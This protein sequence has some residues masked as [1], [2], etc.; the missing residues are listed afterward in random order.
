MAG[1][2][3]FLD[4]QGGV[5]VSDGSGAIDSFLG[6]QKK[7]S[8]IARRALGDTAVSAAKGL[9]GLTEVPVGLADIATGGRLGKGLES[10]G[11]RPKDFKASLDDLYSPEQKAANQAVQEA[12]GFTGKLKAAVQKPST[13]FQT[14]IESAP[15][16]LPGAG[17]ARGL[18]AATKLAPAIAGGIGEGVVGAGLAAEQMRQ[19]SDD[20]LLSGRQTA[21]A[22]ASGAGTA[23]VGAAAVKLTQSAIG[24]KLGLA[25]VDTALAMNPAQRAAM[26]QGQ[27]SIA[28]RAL[29]G[30]VSEGVLEE[31]P[32]SMWEQAAQNYGEGK[33]LGEGV[34][35]A[36]ALGMLAG[37]LMGGGF[38]AAQGL[39]GREQKPA[40]Q[41]EQ[42]AQGGQQASPDNGIDFEPGL[43]PSLGAITSRPEAPPASGMQGVDFESGLVPGV[44]VGAPRPEGIPAGGMRGIDFESVPL[45]EARKAAL[46]AARDE[47]EAAKIEGRRPVPVLITDPAP[48]QQRI[49]EMLG[50]DQSALS[51]KERKHYAKQFQRALDEQVAITNDENGLE[52]PLTMADYLES[53]VQNADAARCHAKRRGPRP[54]TA[55][56]RIV[57]SARYPA[58]QVAGSW[59]AVCGGQCRD[60]PWCNDAQPNSIGGY[61][62]AFPTG[63]NE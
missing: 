59:P 63:C 43:A 3:S 18:G 14:V 23:A 25:D 12:K 1:I 56:R 10:L 2:D 51:P 53:Q 55:G 48:L 40:S 17:V 44:D 31:L 26:Q 7:K 50:V 11:Y 47:Y 60:R 30:A 29:G 49:N 4:D 27:G 6:G 61:Q 16:L 21:A 8:S 41:D 45:D 52:V 34:G 54:A 42:K 39:A 46:W 38:N 24:K 33:D 37:G 15:L 5:S 9:I 28:K 32:Q 22:L 35:E 19:N 36:G 20:G 58:G 13:I 57:F 62:C